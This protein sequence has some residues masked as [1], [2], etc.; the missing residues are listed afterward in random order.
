MAC[1]PCGTGE[2]MMTETKRDRRAFRG[3]PQRWTKAGPFIV[4]Q[5]T[6]QAG[7]EDSAVQDHLHEN[8]HFIFIAAGRY[9]STSANEPQMLV[10]SPSNTIH[11]DHLADGAGCF[12]SVELQKG[13]E[14]ETLEKSMPTNAVS[15]TIGV[16]HSACRRIHALLNASKDEFDL[17]IEASCLDLF[18]QITNERRPPCSAAPWLQTARER[19]A[20]AGEPLTVQALARELSVHSVHLNRSFKAAFGCTPAAYSRATRLK[21]AADL[22]C[23]GSSRLCDIASSCG[24]SDQSHLANVLRRYYGLSP[25]R[26]RRLTCAS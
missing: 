24:F 18:G 17:D 6:V 22:I 14:G 5:W 23:T 11:S 19:L 16:A 9:I 3:T 26:L 4:G 10:F 15:L 20:S 25:G 1:S 8:A 2:V 7:S 13:A 12:L 21:A